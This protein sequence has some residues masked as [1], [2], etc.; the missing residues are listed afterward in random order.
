MSNPWDRAV[1]E[2]AEE[3]PA[4]AT[5]ALAEEVGYLWSDLDEAKRHAINGHW[6]MQCDWLV[7]RIV[8]LTRL[9]GPTS[10][11]E[12]PIT[13]LLDGTYQGILAAADIAF[14]EPDMAEVRAVDAQSRS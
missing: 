12:I 13:L 4:N 6:S 7:T 3:P 14:D 8:R 2:A 10:W 5:A 11:G 1:A 9:A